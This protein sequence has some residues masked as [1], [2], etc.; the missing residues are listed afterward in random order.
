MLNKKVNKM[1]LISVVTPTYNEF[2]NVDRIYEAVKNE[3]SFLNKYNYEHIFIDNGSS[4]HTQD[5]LRELAKKDKNVK[6][7][8][9]TQNFGPKKSPFYALKQTSGQ[10]VILI[11]A[12][13]QEPPTLIREFVQSWEDGFYIVAGIKNKSK[14][15]KLVYM[16]RSIYY[17][18]MSKIS[19]NHH[20]THFTG[21]GL[22]DKSI[23]DQLK[24]YN[25]AEPY[26]RG[27]VPELGHNIK[28]I[29]YTQNKRDMGKTS[30]SFYSLYDF[31]ISG[32]VNHSKLPLRLAAYCGFIG[33]ITSFLIGLIYLFYK[34]FYWDEFSLGIAP[35]VIGLFFITSIQLFF[36]GILGEYVGAIFVQVKQRPLVIE[37][38]RINF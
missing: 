14:E 37:K 35:V 3:F 23:I 1:S 7:I 26:L 11:A 29:T 20:I 2:H 32:I 10:A 8:L 18:I 13:L 24:L 5:K 31:A 21:F 25:D 12:D 28:E 38:E 17:W 4:D 22:Y 19:E 36:L 16:I 15:N 33:S 34:L 9:N 30:T 6:V 27:M